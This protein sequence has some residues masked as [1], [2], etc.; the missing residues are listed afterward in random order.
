MTEGY[1]ELVAGH[2]ARTLLCL[3]IIL[4]G[5]VHWEQQDFLI[6]RATNE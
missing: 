4:R 5:D 2:T 1:K 3:L 6:I